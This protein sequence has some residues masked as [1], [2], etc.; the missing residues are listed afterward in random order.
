M[1]HAKLAKLASIALALMIPVTLLAL[2]PAQGKGKPDKA[3]N[4]KKETPEDRKDGREVA[5][6]L[7]AGISISYGDVRRYAVE[8]DLTGQKPLPPGIR[9][10]LA[11]G[12]PMP[13]GIAKTRLPASFLT[14]L[15]AHKG[16][17]WHAAGVD[18]VLVLKADKS[19]SDVVKDVFE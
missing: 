16:Y 3:K 11:R 15:P 13:P 2:E 6:V 10:N 8:S 1:S 14:R 12:K 19:I 9:K 7:S 17:E 5:I 4:E 18:L